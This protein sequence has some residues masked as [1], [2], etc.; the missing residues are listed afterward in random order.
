V[1]VQDLVEYLVRPL[2]S[3]PDELHV[4]A[5]EGSAS[6]LLEL[7]LYPEDI[8]AVQGEGGSRLR[9]IQ[10]LIAV[11]G[12]PRMPILDLIEYNASGSEE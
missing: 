9:A 10:Q 11:A 7:R 5:I 8:S 3:H 2:I 1:N 12:G 6:V 4:T